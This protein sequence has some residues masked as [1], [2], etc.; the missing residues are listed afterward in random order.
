[1]T[2]ET[3][4]SHAPQSPET[5]STPSP[6]VKKA[7]EELFEAIDH[8]RSAASIL[9][10]RATKD[11]TVR[12]AT[13]EAERV[14]QKIGATAEPLAKHLVAELSKLT[15]NIADTVDG[16]RKSEVPPPPTDKD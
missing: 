14:V 13:A 10:E 8:F 5:E 12:Q 15:R 7:K 3:R 16:R 11:P 4:D 6:D 1:M 9:F 2:D